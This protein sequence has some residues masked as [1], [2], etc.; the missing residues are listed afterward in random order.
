MPKDF[1]EELGECERKTA[2]C[3]GAT[4]WM[5][6]GLLTFSVF[7]SQI[8]VSG[9]TDVPHYA[10]TLM[11]MS[12]GYHFDEVAAHLSDYSPPPPPSF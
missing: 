7:F 10:R 6:L 11:Y 4:C 1:D 9:V 5:F 2:E 3:S 8:P 12:L